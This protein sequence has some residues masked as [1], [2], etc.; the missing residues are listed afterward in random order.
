MPDNR[1]D[2]D[3]T[4]ISPVHD[5]RAEMWADVRAGLSRRPKRLPSKYF[6]DGRGSE[7]FVA[8]TQ[9]PE[10]Y[11]TRAETEIL[12]EHAADLIATARPEE[13]TELGSGASRKTQLLLEAMHD[14]GSGDRYVAFD[15]SE[16]AI[17]GA[18]RNLAV[19]HPWLEVRGVVGDFEADLA[20]I[21]RGGRRMVAFLG[22]TLGNLETGERADFLRRVRSMLSEGDS[23]LLGVDLVKPRE[24]LEAA[25]DDAQGVT[26]DFNRNILRV[27]NRELGAD[28]PAEEFEHVARWVPEKSRVE[29][30]LRS[31]RD[32]TIHFEGRDSSFR[33]AAGEEIHTEI[34]TKFTKESVLEEC[35]TAGL[36]LSLWETD[37]AGRFALSLFRGA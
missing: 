30:H 21:P 10:Y 32:R 8:I 36:E 26:A 23:F 12:E 25:Y 37:D 5:V 9:L 7:L 14:A 35:A 31:P 17:R 3:I 4:R 33:L 20:Q 18:A 28:F 15:V 19:G 6:Y 13:L 24:I 11:P 22:S 1:E 34:S 27:I 16:S 29:M 2:L